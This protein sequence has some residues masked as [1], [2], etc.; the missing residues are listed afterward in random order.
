VVWVNGDG[1]GRLRTEN[2]DLL[3]QLFG[4]DDPDET[5]RRLRR[6]R[7]VTRITL[8]GGRQ[9]WLVTGYSDVRR[10]LAD[11]RLV[12]D[13]LMSP[14]G[15]RLAAG[16]TDPDALIR[17][18]LALDPP[19]HTRLRRLVA[20]AFTANRVAGMRDFVG[21]LVAELL[22]DMDRPGQHDLIADFALP[23]P[24]QVICEMLGVPREGRTA[25]RQWSSVLVSNA[26]SREEY[27]GA[28][29]QMLAYVR[30]LLAAKRVERRDDLLSALVAAGDDGDRLSADE[31][32]S[33]VILLLVAGHD[34]TVNLISGG[35]YRLLAD[36][37]QWERL[38]ADPGRVPAA[39]EE[40]LRYESP[41]QSATHRVASVDVEV[42]GQVIPAGSLVLLSLLSANRDEAH[43]ADAARFD[44]D[45]E[46]ARHVAFGHGI[47]Y[48]LGAPLARLEGQI[49]F[50]SLLTR[51]PDMRLAEDFSPSWKPSVLM[52]G[53]TTLPVLLE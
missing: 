10:L 19:D 11:P 14:T 45:H 35:A 51:Y 16:A 18:M 28:R 53:L 23:L 47:H 50:T 43:F 24:V 33:T 15:I 30:D 44:I 41:V 32:T 37:V 8:H 40:M 27:L 29:S 34:T 31:I 2:E 1:S 46:T 5:L 3:G 38:A 13:G 36:R 17:N 4:G 6:E 42:G 26:I 7:P 39:V 49:A 21:R 20:G 9:G 25:F 48:C 52:R 12:K 22:D